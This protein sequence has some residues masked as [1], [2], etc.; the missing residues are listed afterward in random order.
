MITKSV[1]EEIG[2]MNSYDTWHGSFL[3]YLKK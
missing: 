2:V 3:I 1:S